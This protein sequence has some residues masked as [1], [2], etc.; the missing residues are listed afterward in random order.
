MYFRRAEDEPEQVFTL[1]LRDVCYH[2]QHL[3]S[4]CP[5]TRTAPGQ[6]GMGWDFWSR[7]WDTREAGKRGINGF[8]LAQPC[9]PGSERATLRAAPQCQD[10]FILLG[11]PPLLTGHTTSS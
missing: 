10:E 9:G 7:Q 2:F 8:V 3:F 11:L 1:R 4:T 5:N 6:A